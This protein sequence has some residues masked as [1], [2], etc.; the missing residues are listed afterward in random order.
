MSFSKIAANPALPGTQTANGTPAITLQP[1]TP[2]IRVASQPA[3][4][5]VLRCLSLLLEM[6]FG[7]PLIALPIQYLLQQML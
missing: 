7:M 6:D 2:T 1:L 4:T 5:E 3:G